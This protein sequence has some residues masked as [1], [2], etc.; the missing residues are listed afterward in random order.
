MDKNGGNIKWKKHQMEKRRIF[1]V[2]MC[3]KQ[4]MEK[5]LNGK[6][7]QEGANELTCTCY[8]T[9]YYLSRCFFNPRLVFSFV[10]MDVANIHHN[11]AMDVASIHCFFFQSQDMSDSI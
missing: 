2:R 10:V 1:F 6:E 9:N 8:F 11:E 4:Q 5:K 7:W 3:K